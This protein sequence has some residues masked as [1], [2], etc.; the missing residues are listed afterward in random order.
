M[1]SHKIEKICFLEE[2]NVSDFYDFFFVESSSALEESRIVE[3]K[4][5]RHFQESLPWSKPQPT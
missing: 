4:S 5:E 1:L 3:V 2:S